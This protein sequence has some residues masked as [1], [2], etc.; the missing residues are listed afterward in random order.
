[1]NTVLVTGGAG[2][3]G[4]HLVRRLLA[5]G[6]RVRV[7][8]RFLYGRHGLADV[9]GHAGLEVVEADVRD[10]SAVTRAARGCDA[11]IALAALVGDAACELNPA[12]TVSINL[13]STR[14]IA[15]V[16]DALEIGRLVFASSC[17]VYGAG[18][19]EIL[20]ETSALAPVSLYA[21]T[22]IDSEAVLDGYRDRLSVV[23]LRLATV[24]G[25][26][27][28]M[29]LDLLVNT[30]ASQAVFNGRIRVFGGGQWRPNLHVQDAA[31]AF[32]LA[33]EAPDAAARGEI[34][35]VGDD[36]ANHTVLD[37]ARMVQAA[38][39]DTAVEIAEGVTDQRDYR[40]SFDKITRRLGYRA[41]FSVADGI[42]EVIAAC[43][44]GQISGPSDPHH[45]NVQCL[46]LNGF[47]RARSAP[48]AAAA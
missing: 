12:E 43:R 7:L 11:V 15:E 47:G 8:D 21:R 17:S 18:V 19:D 27:P 24:F 39:P 40:V 23:I 48:T 30:F 13:D 34:F 5:R 37:I 31:A 10:R 14:L 3:V 42:E 38:L 45:S 1:M 2:Y 46:K 32:M 4:S 33:A 6:R 22:R 16:C 44:A 28:R 20:T 36:G 9:L 35:N 41:R 25:L 26:S 29:R